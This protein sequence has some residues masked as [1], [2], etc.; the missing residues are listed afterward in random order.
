MTWNLH[1]L[2]LFILIVS[3]SMR[4]IY[5]QILRNTFGQSIIGSDCSFTKLSAEEAH[6]FWVCPSN[7]TWRWH[8][9]EILT[10]KTLRA[11]SMQKSKFLSF[12]LVSDVHVHIWS[13]FV[14]NLIMGCKTKNKQ[15]KCFIHTRT[16]IPYFSSL[17]TGNFIR[18]LFCPC[19]NPIIPHY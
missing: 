11:T 14:L 6:V 10:T 4:K 1:D 8:A 2:N 15:L 18:A 19:E 17:C 12:H 5:W 7:P 16:I 3:P 9:K 13:T